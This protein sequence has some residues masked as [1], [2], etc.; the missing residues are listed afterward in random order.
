[1]ESESLDKA[2][3]WSGIALDNLKAMRLL[4]N[5]GLLNGYPDSGSSLR[6]GWR[7]VA[8]HSLVQVTAVEVVGELVGLPEDEIRQLK[9][10]A[11]CHDWDIRLRKRPQ[12]LTEPEKLKIQNLIGVLK[13]NAET[14]AATSGFPNQQKIL[15][16]RGE[17]SL[18]AKIL[19]YV[20]NLMM[21][22]EIVSLDERISEVRQRRKDLD[23]N[24]EITQ[25]L[26]G[27]FGH[28]AHYWDVELMLSK[29]V[30]IE[31]FGLMKQR[32]IQIAKPEDIPAFIRG[33]IEK[34]IAGYSD[35]EIETLW[36]PQE[37]SPRRKNED[38]LVVIR[39]DTFMV[40]GVFDGASSLSAVTGRKHKLEP[41]GNI[42]SKAS[43]KA[44]RDGASLY[45]SAQELLIYINQKLAETLRQDGIDPESTS[46]LNLPSAVGTVVRIERE[47]GVIDIAQVGDTICLIKRKGG[48]VELALPLD[49]QK[50]DTEI[51]E[52]AVNL[53]R[54]NKYNTVREA[55]LDPSLAS[56]MEKGRQLNNIPDGNGQGVING[57]P[58]IYPYISTRTYEL[59][60]IDAIILMTD[61]LLPPT[62]N[63]R[64]Q[65]DWKRLFETIEQFG[66]THFY[67]EQVAK[68][69]KE[70]PDLN[71]YPRWK[72]YDDATGILIRI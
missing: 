29:D 37:E 13:P 71:K 9:I 7:N 38:D 55:L 6:E 11:L 42:A 67:Y 23:E 45:S 51:L 44:L 65:Q 28:E 72:Q 66:I 1:M 58:N 54:D 63:P 40:A 64:Q 3:F 35:L 46:P 50:G 34:R 10:D 31:L 53:V 49:I 21:G 41:E 16:F 19:W 48:E 4:K 57:S 33:E 17:L 68:L 15:V 69:K 32:G 2:N 43:T 8:E 24:K 36:L 22:S 52:A 56:A 61:G 39:G 62:K 26:T 47:K 27:A 20:D 5:A 18:P 30:E 59:E 60:E 12:D 70:D 14:I 25:T